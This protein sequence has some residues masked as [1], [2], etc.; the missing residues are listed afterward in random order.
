MRN[1]SGFKGFAFLHAGSEDTNATDDVDD[2]VDVSK[3]LSLPLVVRYRV[4]QFSALVHGQF[5]L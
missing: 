5:W 3:A 2:T 4:I 1:V